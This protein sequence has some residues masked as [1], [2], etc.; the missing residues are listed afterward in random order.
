MKELGLS[1]SD[2]ESIQSERSSDRSFIASEGDPEVYKDGL[3]SG[4]EDEGCQANMFRGSIF[5]TH[6]CA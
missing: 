5:P 1:D 2:S 6:S 4:D 3:E